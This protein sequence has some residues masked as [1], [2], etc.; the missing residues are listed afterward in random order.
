[1]VGADAFRDDMKSFFDRSVNET[2]DMVERQIAVV[3]GERRNGVPLRVTVRSTTFLTKTR[4]TIEQ[5]VL[6]AGGFA[7]SPYLV[8]AIREA[9]HKF[10][11]ISVHVADNT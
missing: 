6:M 1:M 8:N 5:T 4:L 9:I 10:P 11:Q 3:Q 7:G 2:L